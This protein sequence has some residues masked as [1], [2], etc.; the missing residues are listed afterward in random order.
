[1][2]W[3]MVLDTKAKIIKLPEES[4]GKILGNQKLGKDFLYETPKALSIKERKQINWS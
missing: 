3:I 4:T 2:K 1:M